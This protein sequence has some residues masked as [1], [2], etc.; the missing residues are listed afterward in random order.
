DLSRIAALLDAKD[1]PT[2]VA[3]V[4][5]IGTWKL[6]ELPARLIEFIKSDGPL[7]LRRAA[8]TALANNIGT[9]KTSA[10]F[11][12][13]MHSPDA[14]PNEARRLAIVAVSGVNLETAARM[15]RGFCADNPT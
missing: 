2:L 12:D 3:A 11:E 6:S 4:R 14:Y 9:P 13:L 7:E 8:M 1:A 5:L 10:L 15:A